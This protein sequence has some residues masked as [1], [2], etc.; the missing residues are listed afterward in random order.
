MH[1]RSARWLTLAVVA[2]LALLSRPLWADDPDDAKDKEAKVAKKGKK[3]DGPKPA[4]VKAE[5][6]PLTASVT[7]KGVVE[8]GTAAEV[9]V[10]PRAWSGPLVVKK[11]V[12]HGAAVKAGDVLVEFDTEK[13]DQAVKDARQERELADLQV[14]LAELELPILEKQHPL[15][16]AA[17]ER[18]AKHAADDLDK[19]LKVDLPLSKEA[20]GFSLKSSEFYLESA[21]DELKQLE[22]MYKDK[23]LTEETETMILKRYK[24]SVEQAEFSLKQARNRNKQTLEVDLPRREQAAKDAAVKADIGLTKARETGPL[25]LRQKRL[26]LEKMKYDQARAKERFADLEKDL[27][28]MKVTAPADGLAYHGKYARG[29]WMS[30]GGPAGLA[31]GGM[32]P[33]G[34]VVVTVVAPGKLTVRAEADEKE[35]AGLKVGLAGKLTPTAFPDKKVAVELT[36]VA[37]APLGGR[38]ELRA[39]VDGDAAGLVPGMTGQLR[40]VT[41]KKAEAV[42][43][44]ASAVFEDDDEGKYV[45]RPAVGD[46]K[47]K[48]QPVKTGQTAGDKVEIVDG[49]KDGDEVLASKP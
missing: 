33:P 7:V 2:G 21:K 29:A 4:T 34:E 13:I 12:E 6:G 42:L 35:L 11:A 41:A 25:A 27:A 17:A 36:K 32:V 15:D 39:E 24:Q 16:M 46:A 3:G 49:L 20:A 37:T 48:K 30:P 22:K 28:A 47:P 14:R 38:F 40:L 45:Y 19:F 9:Q 5:K 18:D 44:P 1:P 8:A 43:V 31:P 23:D 10:K 26:G